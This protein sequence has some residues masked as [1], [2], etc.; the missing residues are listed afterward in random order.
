MLLVPG[1]AGLIGS[2]DVV[3][4]N[5]AGERPVAAGE[6]PGRDRLRGARA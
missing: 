2:N 4:S 5:G 6:G 1:K 3:V